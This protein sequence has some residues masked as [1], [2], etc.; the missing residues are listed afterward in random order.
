MGPGQLSSSSIGTIHGFETFACRPERD[1]EKMCSD[2]RIELEAGLKA[3]LAALAEHAW[4]SLERI[5]LAHV[6]NAGARE[7][8]RSAPE[9]ERPV[10]QSQ[11]RTSCR[12]G[13][14]SGRTSVDIK[15]Q[16]RIPSADDRQGRLATRRRAPRALA[17]R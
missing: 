6:G 4:R 13:E 15:E 16:P 12:G 8:D 3:A 17:R 5:E 14:G 9:R 1:P 2:A 7:Q 10:E 11:S